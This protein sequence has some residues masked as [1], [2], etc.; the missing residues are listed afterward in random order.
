MS[1][2]R[3]PEWMNTLSEVDAAITACLSALD[4]Y[5]SAFGGLLSE[6]QVPPPP[7]PPPEPDDEWDARLSA[8]AG[9]AA[10]V[11]RLLSEQEAA[12]TNW[13]QR[14]SSWCRSLEHPG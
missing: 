1:E 13:T 7:P 11:E 8:V 5:E 6:N 9:Q 10:D 2:I 12:W 14:F 4:Q 3:T